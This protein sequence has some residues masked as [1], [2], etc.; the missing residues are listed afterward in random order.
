MKNIMDSAMTA[1]A[2]MSAED[3]GKLVLPRMSTL[4]SI[5][6][7]AEYPDGYNLY[8]MDVLYD[9]DLDG[10]VAS[11]IHDDQSMIDAFSH[12]A[13]PGVPVNI[14][15]PNFGCT[16]F[17]MTED[18][19]GLRMGRSY[20]FALDTSAMIVHCAPEGGYKSVATAALDNLAANDP[21]HSFAKK[22]ACLLAPYLCLDGMNEK[23]VCIAVLTLDSTPVYQQTG[24]QMICTALAIRM[25]LDRA[26]TTAE[27]VEL[28]SQYDMFASSGRDY[29]FYITDASGDGRVVEYD[30]D[31]PDRKLVATETPAVTNF[32]ILYKDK[33][34]PNQKNGHYGHGRERYDAA[35]RVLE[36]E[37]G[38]YGEEAAWRGLRAVAQDPNPVDITSNTQWSIVY[39]I[40]ELTAQIA[41]R[42]RW[43]DV[44]H[45]SL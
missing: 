45:Y 2:N 40:E 36:E 32:Y 9:Y 25:V 37:R 33:V 21:N 15:A 31:S 4:E 23:G 11:D 34:L 44:H 1:L 22:A 18:G 14:K 43:D 7:L 13:L 26:A 28:L 10:V 30:C 8:T 12:A 39:N 38:N 6:Q 5:K 42:R 3:L 29:H 41:V 16:A 17:T 24:K 20:D 27:A 35:M 19:H